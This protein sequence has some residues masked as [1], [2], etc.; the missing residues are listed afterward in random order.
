[1]E[2][3]IQEKHLTE[4]FKK[5][6]LIIGRMYY[7]F[8]LID[9]QERKYKK[10]NSVLMKIDGD[11][12]CFLV[13]AEEDGKVEQGLPISSLVLSLNKDVF[14]Y[15]EMSDFI[16]EEGMTFESVSKKPIELIPT[17]E[18]DGFP[19]KDE[20]RKE[21]SK[22]FKEELFPTRK[23]VLD[24]ITRLSLTEGKR[25]A[26]FK[27][28]KRNSDDSYFVPEYKSQEVLNEDAKYF[29]GKGY[30]VRWDSLKWYNELYICW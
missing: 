24:V 10:Y 23:F 4:S 14:Y 12:L 16:L 7:V 1:M 15:L 26:S 17:E 8:V 22:V 5:K 20:I 3:D 13:T 19:T 30:T 11:N 28:D 25:Y 6:D 27:S 21:M 29:K 9:K 18:T 2:K